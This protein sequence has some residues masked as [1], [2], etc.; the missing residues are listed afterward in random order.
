[1]RIG[2]NSVVRQVA[3]AYLGYLKVLLL[4][5]SSGKGFVPSSP[6]MA[7]FI[8]DSPRRWIWKFECATIAMLCGNLKTNEW[9]CGYLRSRDLVKCGNKKA[10]DSSGEFDKS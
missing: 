5:K 1:M 9:F 7:A 6:S 3:R 4:K 10:F 2:S 8:F